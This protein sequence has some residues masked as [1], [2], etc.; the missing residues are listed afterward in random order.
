M[1]KGA[2][3]GEYSQVSHLKQGIKYKFLPEIYAAKKSSSS[4]PI[5]SWIILET[6]PIPGNKG[7]RAQ[8]PSAICALNVWEFLLCCKKLIW[9]RPVEKARSASTEVARIMYS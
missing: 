6:A 4:L 7:E 1:K 3:I 8:E 2:K 5:L 9:R